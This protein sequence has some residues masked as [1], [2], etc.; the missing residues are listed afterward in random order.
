MKPLIAWMLLQAVTF[1][2]LEIHY[3][4]ELRRWDCCERLPNAS[5][6]ISPPRRHMGLY[7]FTAFAV[8]AVV[9]ISYLA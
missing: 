2:A 9:V 3:I 5:G 7:A 8:S 6:V 1:L 4:A